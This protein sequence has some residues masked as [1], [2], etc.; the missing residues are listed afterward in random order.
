MYLKY[1]Q[2]DQTFLKSRRSSVDY[3]KY[4]EQNIIKLNLN[5]LPK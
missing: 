5:Y 1:N 2:R 3:Q 4:L